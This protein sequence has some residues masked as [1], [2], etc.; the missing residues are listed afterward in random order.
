MYADD[1]LSENGQLNWVIITL[2]GRIKKSLTFPFYQ[3]LNAFIIFLFATW[4]FNI[5]SSTCKWN[6]RWNMW[7]TCSMWNTFHFERCLC[8]WWAAYFS[9]IWFKFCFL[10]ILVYITFY[11]ISLEFAVHDFTRPTHLS[12]LAEQKK[13]PFDLM[14]KATVILSWW[15]HVVVH[16]ILFCLCLECF[17]L[18]KKAARKIMCTK[19]KKNVRDVTTTTMSLGLMRYRR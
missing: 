8:S 12:F 17:C 3:M 9:W 2:I 18:K 7:V 15:K 4:N 10:C 6:I 19:R 13:K 14:A 1:V 11:F 16:E 5:I